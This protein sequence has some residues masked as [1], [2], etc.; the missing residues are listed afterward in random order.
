MI[1]IVD[2]QA[3][4]PQQ[5]RDIAGRLRD[6]MGDLVL[7]IDHIGSTA[8][9]G[10]AAKDIIDIQ[11]SAADFSE[12][13]R[14]GL[15]ALGYSQFSNITCDHRPPGDHSSVEM[16]N[17]WL[18]RPPARQRPTN[19]H[20]R[21]LGRANQQY[22]LLFRDYLRNHP[23]TCAAYACLKRQLASELRK[24]GVYPDVK[25]PAVD[26]I[27]LAATDWAIRSGWHAGTSDA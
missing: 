26:L 2:Y 20:I 5:F 7:R 25:G 23:N 24:E 13:V 21:I 27:Y 12:Q 9:P 22:A 6:G 4:W 16:W 19:L 3:T 14:G 8:V 18:F 15:L 10:L 1:E 17:K 11:I